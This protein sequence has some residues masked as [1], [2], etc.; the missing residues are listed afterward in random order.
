MDAFE[1]W[2]RRTASFGDS[3]PTAKIDDLYAGQLR[4]AIEAAAEAWR[5]YHK[6]PLTRASAVSIHHMMWLGA[7][8]YAVVVSTKEES[9]GTIYTLVSDV[10]E[11][12]RVLALRSSLQGVLMAI[13]PRPET[14]HRDWWVHFL[15][16]AEDDKVAEA[17]ARFAISQLAEILSDPGWTTERLY[18]RM[19]AYREHVLPLWWKLLEHGSIEPAQ[20]VRQLPC[21]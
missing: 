3:L 9:R 16:V 6:P 8:E 21:I 5:G 17:E 1:A 13:G 2:L 18:E 14:N 10:L 15:H 4:K 19:L 7:T 12:E 11:T 20:P